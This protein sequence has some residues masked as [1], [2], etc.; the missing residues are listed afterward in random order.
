MTEG[1]TTEQYFEDGTFVRNIRKGQN[2][3]EA[4]G[5][6]KILSD[7]V[8]KTQILEFKVNQARLLQTKMLS[9]SNT[10]LWMTSLLAEM[11]SS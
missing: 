10:I 1:D 4:R 6:Y 3:R 2:M 7:T 8:L 11:T 9:L 5:R